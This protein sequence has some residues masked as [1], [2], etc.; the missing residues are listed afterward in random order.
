VIG[1]KLAAMPHGA[2]PPIVSFH[3][4]APYLDRSGSAEPF[5]ACIS[6]AW[7]AGLDD[8]ALL[9]LGHFT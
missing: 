8:E 1:G 5:R 9:R 3:A 2:A 7:T 4:D 6:T